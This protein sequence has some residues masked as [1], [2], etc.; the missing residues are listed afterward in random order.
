MRRYETEEIENRKIRRLIGQFK[1]YRGTTQM[2]ADYSRFA[3]LR[4]S[5]RRNEGSLFCVL[6]A[7]L[8]LCPDTY[9]ADGCGVVVQAGGVRSRSNC[10][11]RQMGT[12]GF[13]EIR[14]VGTR[15]Q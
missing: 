2:N 3:L 10:A 4:A 7:Q 12:L 11:T 13:E 1:G 15:L 6:T 9:M 8:K 5:L 14:K